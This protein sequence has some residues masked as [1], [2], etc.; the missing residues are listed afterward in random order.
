MTEKSN[1]PLNLRALVKAAGDAI[2]S[3][4]LNG[5]SAGRHRGRPLRVKSR[6]TGSEE[7]AGLANLFF[8]GA[9]AHITVHADPKD[10]QRWEIKCYRM[11]NG[12]EFRTYADGAR[13]VC[14]E[15]LPGRSLR[16]LLKRGELSRRALEAAA[17]EIRRAHQF[18]CRELG[19]GPWSQGDLHMGNVIYDE[20]TNRARLIDFE[21]IHDKS[22]R[23]ATRHADDLLVFLQDMVKWV[24]GRKWLPFALCFLNAYGRK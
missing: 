21:I 11:L 3:I 17:R 9:K 12:D 2:D 7:I 18:R 8:R 24:P 16:A 19:G 10:W 6:R 4:K 23:P 22:L 5:I 14:Q 20:T 13:T 1:I 15:K